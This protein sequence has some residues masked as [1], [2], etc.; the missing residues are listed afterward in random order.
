MFKVAVQSG[1]LEEIYGIDGAYRAIAEAGFDGVDANIDHLMSCGDIIDKK[2]PPVF[3]TGLSEKEII[4]HVK[5]WGDAAK[6]YGLDNYQAHAPFPSLHTIDTQDGDWNDF[7]IEMLKKTI[8]CAAAIDCHNLIVHPF[9][10]DYDHQMDREE[11]WEVNID[12]YSR[13]AK[14]AQQYGVV[15]NLENMF[16]GKN[17]K[18]YGTVCNDGLLAAR[19]VDAL[20]EAAGAK[21]FGFCLD[22][23]HALLASKDIKQFMTEMGSRITCFHVH[24][25][26]GVNDLHQAPYTGKLDWDRFVEGLRA[27][28]F[29]KT[30]S[31]ETFNVCRTVAPE[32]I[33]E[34]LKYIAAC[35][36]LF[37]RRASEKASAAQ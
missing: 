37:D 27:I 10:R 24:D 9:L 33:P 5:P 36:R 19:Y 1:G 12:R 28:G 31:F 3:A 30:L 8:I 6:K 15:I 22:T 26:D 25:N 11:E 7:L 17:G 2:I 23:G 14:T 20:N 35:G 34:A 18:N 21:C 32:L 29:D 13:L 16:F 4:S